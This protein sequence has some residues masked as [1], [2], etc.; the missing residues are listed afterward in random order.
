MRWIVSQLSTTPVLPVDGTGGCSLSA[1]MLRVL[2]HRVAHLRHTG[3]TGWP[4]T[5]TGTPPIWRWSKLGSGSSDL[6]KQVRPSPTRQ[7]LLPSLVRVGKGSWQQFFQG[8]PKGHRAWWS[9][10]DLSL[11]ANSGCCHLVKCEL[12]TPGQAP[13]A[14]APLFCMCFY[15]L[16]CWLI[17][18]HRGA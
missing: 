3:G 10:K 15:G 9:Q 18:A 13:L 12:T 6:G 8:F 11:S 7:A 16:F 1:A 17:L 14:S 4:L 5:Q 2:G